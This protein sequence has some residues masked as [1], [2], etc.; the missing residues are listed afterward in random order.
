MNTDLVTRFWIAGILGGLAAMAALGFVIIGPGRFD[1]SPPSL[2]GDPNLAIPGKIAYAD[3]EG[4][5]HVV[6]ASGQNHVKLTC[7]D[8]PAAVSFAGGNIVLFAR[9][10]GERYPEWTAIDITTGEQTNLGTHPGGEFPPPPGVEGISIGMD[11]EVV[12]EGES[13][14]QVIYDA[15]YPDYY[16]PSPLALSPD[17]RWVLLQYAGPRSEGMELWIVALDGSTAGTIA[18]GTTWGLA[19]ASW[20]IE[21]EGVTPDIGAPEVP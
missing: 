5:I 18:K 8:Y 21:G 2:R 7:T 19:S 6:D 3:V 12:Y 9:Y 1:P 10:A 17:G 4:C 16:R 13:G 11:G 20:W 15:S 14:R